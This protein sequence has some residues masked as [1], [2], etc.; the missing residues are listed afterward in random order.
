MLPSDFPVV[1]VRITGLCVLVTIHDPCIREQ[2]R[3][4]TTVVIKIYRHDLSAYSARIPFDWWRQLR[5]VEAIE[6]TS[7]RDIE[8][9]SNQQDQIEVGA[10]LE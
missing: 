9:Y 1:L 7:R 6:Q 4:H 2:M 8:D 3:R 10:A 5:K